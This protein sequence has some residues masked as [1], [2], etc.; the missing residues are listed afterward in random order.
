MIL[1]TTEAQ[2]VA[3][4]ITDITTSIYMLEDGP[5]IKPLR[6]QYL[7]MARKA[8]ATVELSDKFGIDLPALDICRERLDHYRQRALDLINE[9][10]SQ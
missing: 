7:F 6:Q 8:E 5:D 9:E 1:T 4:L 2:E 3:D 10:V